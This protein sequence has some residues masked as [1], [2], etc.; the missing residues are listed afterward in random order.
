MDNKP[1]KQDYPYAWLDE[2]VE[3]TLNPEKSNVTNLETQ[4]LEIIEGKFSDEL[5]KVLN[6][7]KTNTFYLFSTK[8]IKAAVTNYYD[9]LLLLEKQAMANLAAYPNDHPLA[10]TGEQLILYIQTMSAAFKKR[11]GKYI[12]QGNFAAI[13]ER[14]STPVISKILCKLSVD[15]IGIILRAADDSKV[16]LASSLSIIFR[17]IVPYLST[18]K[19]KQISWNSMRKSTYQIEQMDKEVAIAT[20]EKLILKIKEY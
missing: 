18:E 3:I 5:Q 20:L 12:T 9:S 10:V 4:Q 6:D 17:S 2:V 14:S 15:Q 8:K 16:I 1:I 13:Q 11:Y 7:L 19:I